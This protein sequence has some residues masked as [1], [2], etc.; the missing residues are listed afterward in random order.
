MK[1]KELIEHLIEVY[2]TALIKTKKM[3]VHATY[4]YLSRN[5]LECGICYYIS[6]NLKPQKLNNSWISKRSNYTYGYIS[7]WY[8]TPRSMYNDSYYKKSDIT[9]TLKVR[10]EILKE[11]LKTCK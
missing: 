9:N 4:R 10:L 8:S 2:E 7:H 3:N 6:F 11:N 1:K 5:Y